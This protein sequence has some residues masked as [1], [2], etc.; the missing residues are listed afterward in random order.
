MSLVLNS[1]ALGWLYPAHLITDSALTIRAFGPSI[2]RAFPNIVVGESLWAHFAAERPLGTFDVARLLREREQVWLRSPHGL[3]LRGVIV[4]QGDELFFL[5]NYAPSTLRSDAHY[6]LQMWDFSPADATLDALIAVEVQKAL[7]AETQDVLNEL[8]AARAA[9]EASHQATRRRYDDL[10][11][12]E[13]ASR[14]VLD[15]RAANVAAFAPLDVIAAACRLQ[16]PLF[17]AR[18][19]TL[20]ADID[21]ADDRLSLG[22]PAA[23]SGAATAMLTH[24]LKRSEQGWVKLNA[25]AHTDGARLQVLVECLDTGATDAPDDDAD[26]ADAAKRLAPD[27]GRLERRVLSGVGVKTE[28][29]IGYR[30]ASAAPMADVAGGQARPPFRLLVVC[31]DP[32]DLRLIEA[33]LPPPSV[34]MTV[35]ATEDA[36]LSALGEQAFDL[37]LFDIHSAAFDVLSLSQ[38]IRRRAGRD[39]APPIVVMGTRSVISHLDDDLTRHV[40]L[41]AAKPLSPGKLLSLLREATGF[42]V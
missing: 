2:A 42:S 8:T 39:R 16:T 24:A 13:G 1:A 40:D 4:D 41:L 19:V 27:G 25:S 21:P 15:D 6:Q 33:T 22:D 23:L 38:A 12:A 26:L 9:A 35:A 11:G 18:G 29:K 20:Q 30:P 32:A 17:R 37:A 5:V 10:V 7:I 28:L 31:H 36:V 3:K 14:D 34:E